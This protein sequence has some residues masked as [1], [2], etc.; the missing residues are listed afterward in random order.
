M[1]N[2]VVQVA[3]VLALVAAIGFGYWR[4]IRPHRASTEV[5]MLLGLVMM[6]AAGGLI[7]STGWWTD[8]PNSFSWDL[9]PLASRL[10]GAAGIAFSVAAVMAM[11]RPTATRLRLI[12]LML[13]VYLVPLA[14]AIVAFHLDRFNWSMPITYAFFAIVTA[15]AVPALWFVARR[16]VVLAD[17]GY[18]ATTPGQ[19]TRL[20]FVLVALSTGIWGAAL[21]LTDSGPLGPVWVWPGDLLTSRLIAVM[22]LTI[23]AACLYSIRSA[24]AAAVTLAIIAVYGLGAAV[25]GLLNIAAEKPV[26]ALYVLAL[27]GIGAVSAG[28]F[29]TARRAHRPDFS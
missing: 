1:N 28:M 9:P 24:S 16:P 13:T 19:A 8:N 4:W 10:L 23:A 27:G 5:N 26:P 21:F 2:L 17:R 7:G 6:T 15:M 22:L 20:W 25:A 3:G 18:E 14:L 12:M 29:V 11:R